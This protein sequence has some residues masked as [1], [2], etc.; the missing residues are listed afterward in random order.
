MATLSA[1]SRRNSGAS[2]TSSTG[3]PRPSLSVSRM[4]SINQEEGEQSPSMDACGNNS[5]PITHHRFCF[6]TNKCL[7]NNKIIDKNR[8]FGKIDENSENEIMSF[9]DNFVDVNG[10]DDKNRT[11][12]CSER[13]DSGISDCS[14]IGSSSSHGHLCQCAINTTPLLSKKYSITEDVESSFCDENLKKIYKTEIEPKKEPE[15]VVGFETETKTS[16]KVNEETMGTKVDNIR[17]KF[18][19]LSRNIDE[20]DKKLETVGKKLVDIGPG[21]LT[22]AKKT[23]IK[24]VPSLK[25]S[26]ASETKKSHLMQPTASSQAK[27][28]TPKSPI[29]QRPGRESLGL[30]IPVS[31]EL[32][33]AKLS[34][35]RSSLPPLNGGVKN[36]SPCV[37]STVKGKSGGSLKSQTS[38]DSGVGGDTVSIPKTTSTKRADFVKLQQMYNAKTVSHPS[39]KSIVK[40]SAVKSTSSTS[41]CS[42]KNKDL[43]NPVSENLKNTQSGNPNF[44]K[45]VAFWKSN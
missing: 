20:M 8:T 23:E 22:N 17:K 34:R 42:R 6:N 15:T 40:D 26:K 39:N 4:S 9:R 3:S 27:I 10:S 44:Q 13:S 31:P 14:S 41:S 19:N 18:A 16:T 36:N 21:K 30:T 11:R 29:L 38:V 5:S 45:T 35:H 25:D 28:A 12:I 32:R 33:T 1:A 7:E 2:S 37:S 24:R 43:A